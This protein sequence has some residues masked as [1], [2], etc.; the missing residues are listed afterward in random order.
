[1]S[2]IQF[3][4]RTKIECAKLVRNTQASL[5]S[6]MSMSKTELKQYFNTERKNICA[7]LRAGKNRRNVATIRIMKQRT[8]K[9]I[10]DVEAS[11]YE[12]C[13]A[14]LRKTSERPLGLLDEIL[15]RHLLQF[16]PSV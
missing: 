1:M 13:K 7:Q 8:L 2:S 4:R 11:P 3:S 6:S 10:R 9:L 14:F 5:S 16:R 12:D 15:E